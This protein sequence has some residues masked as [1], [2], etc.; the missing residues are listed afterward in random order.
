MKKRILLMS[1]VVILFWH[2]NA[3]QLVIETVNGNNIT[4]FITKID[5]M[6]FPNNNL[7]IIK[8][9][10][11]SATLNLLQIKKLYFNTITSVNEISINPGLIKVFPNP[12]EDYI[13]I[14][15]LSNE[16]AKYSI[17]SIYGSIVLQSSIYSSES[18]IDISTLHKGVYFLQISGQTI[19]FIKQ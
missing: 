17:F 16:K 13:T 2:S 4:E 18:T 14:S 10:E 7:E 19:K 9:D 12:A 1:L 11:T 8:T 3:Q 15:N 6:S 5:E